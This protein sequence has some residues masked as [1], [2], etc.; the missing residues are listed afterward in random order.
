MQTRPLLVL[1]ALAAATS[2][3]FGKTTLEE[4]KEKIRGRIDE[5]PMGAVVWTV[6]VGAYVFYRAEK[7]HN[8]KVTS[9][10]DALVYVSTNLSV[11]Y[12]DIFARTPVGKAVGTAVMT[13]GPAMSGRILDPPATKDTAPDPVVERLDKILTALNDRPL[14]A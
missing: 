13:Y 8:P 10:Y 11:G 4:L 7:G 9:Y 3:D 2:P 12:A 6:L 1:A 14:R 5:D